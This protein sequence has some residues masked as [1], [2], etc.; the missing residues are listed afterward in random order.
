MRQMQFYGSW[1]MWQL[2]VN[3]VTN[4]GKRFHRMS[5]QTLHYI[6]TWCTLTEYTWWPSTARLVSVMYWWKKKEKKR[7]RERKFMGK[8]RGFPYWRSTYFPTICYFSP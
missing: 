4:W 7:I 5:Q 3:T 1:C 2:R 8:I 6:V